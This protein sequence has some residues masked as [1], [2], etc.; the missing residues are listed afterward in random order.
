MSLSVQSK[1]VDFIC[2]SYMVEE[3]ELL[4]DK[5]LVDQGILDS[6]G[7]IEIS[8]FAKQE[9]GIT[10]RPE[11]MN[12]ENFGSVLKLVSFIEGKK[13][14]MQDRI[15]TEGLEKGKNEDSSA[16]LEEGEI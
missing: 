15:K 4:L 9:F 2:R 6:F 12:R 7:L 3:N 5:S 14:L 1:L 10:V 16:E 11:E 13:A 8:A